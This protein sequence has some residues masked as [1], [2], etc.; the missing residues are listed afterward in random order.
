MWPVS[1]DCARSPCQGPD[2]QRNPGATTGSSYI[3]RAPLSQESEKG[4]V[5]VS[6]LWASGRVGATEYGLLNS[7]CTTE[8]E[9]HI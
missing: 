6:R 1:I 9:G 5:K 4:Q 8:A 3:F 7:I 2:H